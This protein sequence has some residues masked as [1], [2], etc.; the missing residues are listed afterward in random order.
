MWKIC[1]YNTQ[2]WKRMTGVTDGLNFNFKIVGRKQQFEAP[3][4]P[5]SANWALVV[6]PQTEKEL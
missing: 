3:P 4:N 5:Q 2:F 1:L 6:S